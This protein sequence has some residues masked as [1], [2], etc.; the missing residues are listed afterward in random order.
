MYGIYRS[1]HG[2]CMCA[3]LCVD[4]CVCVETCVLLSVESRA[5]RAAPPSSSPAAQDT[6]TGARARAHTHTHTHT[7]SRG[8]EGWLPVAATASQNLLICMLM[9][10]GSSPARD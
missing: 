10:L 4:V 3:Y 2:S 9:K 5:M 7:H 1:I 6:R 8:W